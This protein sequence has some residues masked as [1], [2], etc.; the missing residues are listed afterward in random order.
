M[1]SYKLKPVGMSFCP[2]CRNAKLP[3]VLCPQCGFYRGRQLVGAE[4]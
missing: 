1:T 3:H 4:G 2:R